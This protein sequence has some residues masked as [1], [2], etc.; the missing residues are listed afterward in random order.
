MKHTPP[1]FGAGAFLLGEGREVSQPIQIFQHEKT[2][3]EIIS[4]GGFM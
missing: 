2:T 4:I 3:D 1:H